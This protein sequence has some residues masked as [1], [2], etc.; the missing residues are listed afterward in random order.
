MSNTADKFAKTSYNKTS[1]FLGKTQGL[2][3]SSAVGA[4]T[5]FGTSYNYGIDIN[6]LKRKNQPAVTKKAPSPSVSVSN[7]DKESRDE[8]LD[9][10]SNELKKE[11]DNLKENYRL[12]S[13]QYSEDYGFGKE[14]EQ[15]QDQEDMSEYA[16][17]SGNHELTGSGDMD[18][19]EYTDENQ[20][21]EGQND[22][23]DESNENYD[24][25]NEL[26]ESKE[27]E[28]TSDL[29]ESKDRGEITSELMNSK[30]KESG[31][32]YLLDSKSGNYTASDM[33]K[34]KEKVVTNKPK[35]NINQAEKKEN[36][37][38]SFN[39]DEYNLDDSNFENPETVK[40]NESKY[41]DSQKSPVEK[42]QKQQKRK[43]PSEVMSD[44]Y[45]SDWKAN[46]EIAEQSKEES[47]DKKITDEEVYDFSKESISQHKTPKGGRNSINAAKKN[48]VMTDDIYE[49]LLS[50][51][52]KHI[53]KRNS[54][55]EDSEIVRTEEL[56]SGATSSR[57]PDKKN[58]ISEN[59]YSERL[60]NNEISVEDTYRFDTEDND[61]GKNKL[62]ESKEYKKNK[63]FNSADSHDLH[64][65]TGGKKVSFTEFK[66][67]QLEKNGQPFVSKESNGEMFV[68]IGGEM[69]PIVVNFPTTATDF[70]KSIKERL[71]VDRG[72]DLLVQNELT[73]RPAKFEGKLYKFKVADIFIHGGK[74]VTL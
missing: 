31:T 51:S 38:E 50:E 34:S 13:D 61:K 68:D 40:S 7:T 63:M 28:V 72:I 73:K 4:K 5:G 3:T 29:L 52:S 26:L 8:F 47:T 9:E 49:D 67:K 12:G 55:Y 69:Y 18:M 39:Y 59:V 41:T 44:T 15:D 23:E 54:R 11:E 25:T 48:S 65:E 24:M 17:P 58:T 71:Y 42:R 46:E 70:K 45:K 57:V 60:K 53:N 14:S 32:N 22:M 19:G 6:S 36:L 37:V 20:Y 2:A 62:I 66:R 27:R 33:V 21:T 16:S 10:L 43:P 56:I 35:I 74:Y 30:E 64:K 1:N